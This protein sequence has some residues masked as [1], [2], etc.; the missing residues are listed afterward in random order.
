MYKDGDI[1]RPEVVPREWSNNNFNFDD[2]S[3]AMLTLFTV[4]TFEGWP[5]SVVALLQ[6][7]HFLESTQNTSG[8]S[9][10]TFSVH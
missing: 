4:S 8:S 3:Q 1:N 7:F 6:M 5:G 2:V 10:H 9:A